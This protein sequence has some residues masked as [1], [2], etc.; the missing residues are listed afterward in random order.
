MPDFSYEKQQGI[1]D[2]IVGLDEAGRGPWCGPVVAACVGWPDLNC[3]TELAALLDDSKKLT[4]QKRALLFDRIIASTPVWGIGQASAKEID[5][6][7][8]LQAS[9]LAMRRAVDEVIQKGYTPSVALIDGNRLPTW[10]MEKYAIIGGDGKS[11]SIAAA[12]ILAKVTRDRIMVDLAQK[13]PYYGWEK[14]AGYGTKTHQEGLAQHGIT[15]EHRL[16]YAP[17]KK[18][19]EK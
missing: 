15:P 8:I 10:D 18:F 14:N 6:I 9:F 5:E 2:L 16:S 4:P 17:I 1:S 19:L 13:Y 3:P 11:L 7:N 12:S